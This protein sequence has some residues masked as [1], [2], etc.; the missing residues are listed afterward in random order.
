MNQETIIVS[1]DVGIKNLSICQLLLQTNDQHNSENKETEKKYTILYWNNIDIS[2]SPQPIQIDP[3]FDHIENEKTQK[4]KCSACTQKSTFKSPKGSFLCTR[5]ANQSGYLHPSKNI[6]IGNLKSNNID[7][8]T[9]I[10]CTNSIP[11]STPHPKTKK[12]FIEMITDY[13]L[14]H[15]LVP[16][17]SFGNECIY[18]AGKLNINGQ[19]IKF[20]LKPKFKPNLNTIPE[21]DNSK[22]KTATNEIHLSDIGRNIIAHLD[23]T[24]TQNSID[25]VIIE[26]QIGPLAG[27]MKSIQ[28]MLVQYFIMR[29]N[30]VKVEFVGATVK[31]KPFVF[32]SNIQTLQNSEIESQHI[33]YDD[34]ESDLNEI[35][36]D[37]INNAENDKIKR[38]A[39]SE[40]KKTGVRAC[41]YILNQTNPM[42]DKWLK[43]MQS[44]KKKDD[45][46]DC[47]LQVWSTY[48]WNKVPIVLSI[49]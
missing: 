9:N 31:L 23:P 48:I 6:K 42:D 44:N 16:L 17:D 34:I 46:C 49:S 8:L 11:I 36:N 19:K 18:V 2:S 5:H 25:T 26:N 12:A 14:G 30:N 24:F 32:G 37:N 27:R 21:S 47:F 20:K 10:C 41:T 40:R 28:A 15:T 7:E 1:I 45:L 4:Q 43:Y 3:F 33:Y 13:Y 29:H 35:A 38:R 39:Y 22:K